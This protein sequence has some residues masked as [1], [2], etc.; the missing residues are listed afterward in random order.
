[1]K[2]IVKVSMPVNVTPDESHLFKP[3]LSYKLQPPRVRYLK[4]VFITCTGLVCGRNGLIKE[5]CHYDWED[6]PTVCFARACE[7]YYTAKEDA[8]NLLIFDDDET[9][10]LI[11]HPWHHN[12]Y[13]W[14]NETIYRLWVIKEAADQMVLLLPSQDQLSKFALDSL[15]IF[16]FK[17]IVYIPPGKSALVRKLCLPAQKPKMENYNRAALLEIKTLFLNYAN[18]RNKHFYVNERIFVSRRNSSRR[19]IL[20]E[21]EVIATL[22]DYNFSVIYTEDYTFLE[23]I[24]IF[25]Q[26]KYLTGNHG[27]GLTNMLFMPADSIIFEFHKRKTNPIRHQNLLYWYMADALGHKYYQQICEPKDINELFFSADIIVDIELLNK[28]LKLIFAN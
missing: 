19:K 8:Q 2:N 3:Y 18:S 21:D 5:C 11:H 4:N 9:Y 12:Y 10:L 1:M 14:L 13:H 16:T 25:S 15:S 17:S 24:A 22:S 7:F 20:N 28:N 27:A 23:Q 6:Q 26:V